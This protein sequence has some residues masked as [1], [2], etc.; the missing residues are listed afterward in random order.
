MRLVAGRG[1]RPSQALVLAVGV[2]AGLGTGQTHRPSRPWVSLPALPSWGL[3]GWVP[4]QDRHTCV[5]FSWH[6]LPGY[7]SQGTMRKAESGGNGG[8]MGKP[9]ENG[10]GVGAP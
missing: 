3:A 6:W 5:P 9:P 7:E 2:L 4:F 8:P 1:C 10:A